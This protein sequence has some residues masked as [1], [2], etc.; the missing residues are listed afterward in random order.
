M[1]YN[2]IRHVISVGVAIF[3]QT[4]HCAEGQ[5][6]V[7]QSAILTPYGLMNINN[8]SVSKLP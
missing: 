6:V 7:S 8:T 4:V 3:V 2:D 1:L 5:L